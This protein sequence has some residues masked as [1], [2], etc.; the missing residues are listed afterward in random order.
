[1]KYATLIYSGLLGLAVAGDASGAALQVSP[2]SVTVAAPGT[3]SSVTLQN[4][5]ERPLSAQLRIYRWRQVDGH[6]DYEETD[7]VVASPPLAELS[8]RQNYTVRIVRTD[9][10]PVTQEEAYRLIVDELPAP[11]SR[12]SSSITLAMRYSIPVFFSNADGAPPNLVWSF[13]KNNG[14]IVLK[15]RNDGDQ[16]VR[17][18]SLKLRDAKGATVSFGGGLIGYALGHSEV[19]F[20]SPP[21]KGFSGGSATVIAESDQGPIDAATVADH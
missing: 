10:T 21:A 17:I 15:L 19:E 13:H 14:R 7:A 8:S 11:N 20:T 16:H 5:D 4:I 1:M 18:S 12:P 6:D 2:V 3:T 9:P